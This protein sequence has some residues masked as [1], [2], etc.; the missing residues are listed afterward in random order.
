MIARCLVA[1]AALVLLAAC[2]G[3]GSPSA[4][5]PAAPAPASTPVAAQPATAAFTIVIPQRGAPANSARRPTYIT[6]NVQGID[7]TV[8]GSSGQ[9][10]GY[11][12]YPLTPQATYCS[13]A[14]GPLTCTLQVN[15][16]AGNDTIV[17]TTYDSTS[18]LTALAI[19]STSVTQTISAKSANV[20]N[21]VTNP[22]PFNI[23]M[24]SPTNGGT[25]H[26][27][28]GGSAPASATFTDGDNLTFTG[29]FDGPLAITLTGSPHYSLSQSTWG[30]TNSPV[31]I[32]NDGTVGTA[33]LTLTFNGTTNAQQFNG[34]TQS[35]FSVNFT[36]ITP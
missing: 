7:F 14:G 20:I 11:V 10:V 19:S 4:S 36:A 28:T 1:T 9:I 27:P 2:G 33:S 24:V 25:L 31:A 6:P 13:N 26:V 12:F 21:A 22:V 16:P 3:S 15:A 29:S 17:I 34:C 30:A 32:V 35:C 18:A 23:T 8:A 5:L